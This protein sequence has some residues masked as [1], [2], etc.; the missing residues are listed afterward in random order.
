MYSNHKSDPV[1]AFH[2][3]ESF[4]TSCHFLEG[5]G[6]AMDYSAF[7]AENQKLIEKIIFIQRKEHPSL[8]ICAFLLH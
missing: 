4:D 1:I 6:M 3:I 7:Q 5:C 8:R 2:T